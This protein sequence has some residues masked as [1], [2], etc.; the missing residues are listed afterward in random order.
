MNQVKPELEENEALR[1]MHQGDPELEEN[2]ALRNMHRSRT[3]GLRFGFLNANF[4]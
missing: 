2:E 1:N 3:E 4:A